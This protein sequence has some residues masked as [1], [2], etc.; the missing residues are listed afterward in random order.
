MIKVIEM[1]HRALETQPKVYGNSLRNR[2]T[3]TKAIIKDKIE[4]SFLGKKQ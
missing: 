2:T 1:K 4:E 3:Q